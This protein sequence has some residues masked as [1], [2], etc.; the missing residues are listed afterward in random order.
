MQSSLTVQVLPLPALTAS[1][2]CCRCHARSF[3]R[4]ISAAFNAKLDALTR[5]MANAAADNQVVDLQD[6]MYRFT[7]DSFG[8]IGFGVDLGCLSTEGPVP[9]AAAFDR[10]QV[11][12]CWRAPTQ[13]QRGVL[14]VGGGV[15]GAVWSH[16]AATACGLQHCTA[17]ALPAALSAQSSS[18]CS[19]S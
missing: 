15:Q 9:F 3:K 17:E 11:V 4:Y 18:G 12:C 5:R 10:A 1:V 6:I 14:F 8:L 13:Q 7:L 19:A 16:A 2:P